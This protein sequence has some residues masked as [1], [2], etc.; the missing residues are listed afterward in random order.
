MALGSFSAQRAELGSP[1]SIAKARAGA[2]RK[3]YCCLRR[4]R[5]PGKAAYPSIRSIRIGRLTEEISCSTCPG[6]TAWIFGYCHSRRVRSPSTFAL[7]QTHVN[8]GVYFA[9][10]HYVPSRDGQ[11]FLIKTQSSDPAPV[12]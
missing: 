7:F 5:E 4:P 12:P 9:R 2:E 3:T 1:S 6:Q 10:T 11:R 8:P